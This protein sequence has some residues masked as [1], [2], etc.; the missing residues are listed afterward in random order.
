MMDAD[1]EWQQLA[2][3]SAQVKTPLD[4]VIG[5]SRSHSVLIYDRVQ[6]DMVYIGLR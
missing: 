1:S 6:L 3:L 5:E 4:R 2:L